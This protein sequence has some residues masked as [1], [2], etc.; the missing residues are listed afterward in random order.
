MEDST[1]PVGG[2][3]AAARWDGAPCCPSCDGYGKPLQATTVAGWRQWRCRE[4]RRKFTAATGTRMHSTKL[5]P[6]TWLAAA[7]LGTVSPNTLAETLPLSRA[8]AY[9][10]ASV[11]KPAAGLDVPR[12]VLYLLESPD[13][14]REVTADPWLK[15]PLPPH[16][17]IEDNPLPQ[18]SHGAKATINALRNRMF[19]ATAAKV[20]ELSGASYSHTCK[21][22]SDLQRRGIVVSTR[23]GLGHGDGLRSKTVWRLS[24]NPACHQVI[25]FLRFRRVTAPACDPDTVPSRFWWHFWSGSHGSELRISQHGLHVAAA[26]L[27]SRDVGAKLW[28]LQHM[29]EPILAQCRE[30]RGLDTAETSGMISRELRRRASVS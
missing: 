18:F 24:W 19:G 27:G 13:E 6:K 22:L 3:F 15:T 5:S 23:R 21:T 29:P 26:L 25:R 10:V 2:D 20:A 12:R 7:A 28:A 16:L 1:T 8:T 4:C 11:L 9:R 30:M 17:S 14:D